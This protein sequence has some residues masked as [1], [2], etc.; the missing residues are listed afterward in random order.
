MKRKAKKPPKNSHAIAC[1]RCSGPAKL[2]YTRGNPTATFRRRECLAACGRFTTVE[3]VSGEKLDDQLQRRNST[4]LL[5]TDLL[6]SVGLTLADLQTP[7]TI[8]TSEERKS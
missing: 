8:P 2:V 1:P 5:V 6:H 7:V 4:A 3:R